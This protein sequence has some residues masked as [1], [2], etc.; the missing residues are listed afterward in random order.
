MDIK[1][2]TE[3]MAFKNLPIAEFNREKCTSTL[4]RTQ[5]DIFNYDLVFNMIENMG[6]NRSYFAL[7]NELF[8]DKKK[9]HKKNM[10]HLFKKRVYNIENFKEMIPDPNDKSSP[11]E[12]ILFNIF[13]KIEEKQHKRNNNTSSI[14][15]NSSL[16]SPRQGTGAVTKTTKFFGST[17]ET[18]GNTL[19]STTMNNTAYCQSEEEEKKTSEEAYFKNSLGTRFKT[20]INIAERSKEGAEKLGST[21]SCWRRGRSEDIIAKQKKLAEEAR[22]K[23][24]FN[25]DKSLYSF[26]LINKIIY[27]EK[28]KK[29]YFETA[30]KELY[31]KY[32][33]AKNKMKSIQ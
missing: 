6:D 13:S 21:I 29:D 12:Q 24:Y 26:P 14:F 27:K 31:Q 25:K 17:A 20:I 1:I 9:K 18:F 23:K 3:G 33:E 22:K 10:D 7:K 15:S 2:N 19:P 11:N 32:I 28:K 30:K 4:Q 16:I 8:G 5:Y